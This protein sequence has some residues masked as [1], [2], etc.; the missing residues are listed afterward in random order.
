M[1]STSVITQT[2]KDNYAILKEEFP[3]L[4]EKLKMINTELKV[5]EGKL[6]ELDAP[7]TPGRI[8]E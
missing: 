6:D 2:E 4:L 3:P 5:L 1:R 7:W 8:P